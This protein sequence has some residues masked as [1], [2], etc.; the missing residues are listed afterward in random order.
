MENTDTLKSSQNSFWHKNDSET[1][2][3][4]QSMQFEYELATHL[5]NFILDNSKDQ[6]PEYLS[7]T[8]TDFLRIW[9]RSKI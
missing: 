1:L 9:N 5:K 4:S 6:N 8:H 3:F 2:N 7:E